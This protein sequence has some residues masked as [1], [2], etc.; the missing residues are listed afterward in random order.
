MFSN[1]RQ[2]AFG[3]H[4]VVLF[5]VIGGC[6]VVVVRG[7]PPSLL[8]LGVKHGD[9]V[10]CRNTDITTV[11]VSEQASVYVMPSANP[12]HFLIFNFLFIFVCETCV[13]YW[14]CS[15]V[16]YFKVPQVGVRVKSITFLILSQPLFLILDG[17]CHEVKAEVWRMCTV[18]TVET[19]RVLG[20]SDSTRL[21]HYGMVDV[22]DRGLP[23]WNYNVPKLTTKSWWL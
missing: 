15:P 1:A 10:F 3:W 18:E 8:C 17:K 11:W 16:L 13:N 9:H 23:W 22:M 19:T 6:R 5:L 14:L 4:T 21:G 2:C 12:I 20:K 7:V